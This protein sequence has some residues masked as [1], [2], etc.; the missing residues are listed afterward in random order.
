MGQQTSGN[1]GDQ[2]GASDALLLRLLLSQDGGLAEAIPHPGGATAHYE[3]LRKKNNDYGNFCVGAILIH[4]ANLL[5]V[6]V[7]CLSFIKVK[8]RFVVFYDKKTFFLHP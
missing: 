4:I 2:A 6:Q 5:N 1:V 3:N 8:N 7:H